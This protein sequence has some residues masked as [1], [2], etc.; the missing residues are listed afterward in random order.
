MR[1]TLL[2]EL[3]HGKLTSSACCLVRADH[4]AG[5]TRGHVQGVHGDV[6]DDGCAVGIGNDS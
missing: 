2:N 1:H 4:K 5:H 6:H 3:I